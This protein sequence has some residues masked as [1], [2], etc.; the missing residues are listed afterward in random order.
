MAGKCT[1]TGTGS[2]NL[3]HVKRDYRSSPG[4]T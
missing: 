1:Y 4:N 2:G 3:A